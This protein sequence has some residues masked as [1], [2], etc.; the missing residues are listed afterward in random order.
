MG[1]PLW[2][3]QLLRDPH[4]GKHPLN[5]EIQEYWN[6]PWLYN[7]LQW[8]SQYIPIVFPLYSIWWFRE[9]GVPPNHPFLDGIFSINYSFWG[10]PILGTPHIV[11]DTCV[12]SPGRQAA[13]GGGRL[14]WKTQGVFF[15]RWPLLAA[16]PLAT[17]LVGGRTSIH[18]E[19][20][21]IGG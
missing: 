1:F 7:L 2:T 6:N 8:Y 11:N 18:V 15:W 3:I 19:K 20:G 16:R 9:I 17:W 13:D 4:F 10:T 12:Q 21:V 14:Q 5:D